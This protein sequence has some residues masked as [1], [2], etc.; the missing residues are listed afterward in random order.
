MSAGVIETK[1]RLRPI[2]PGRGPQAT[3]MHID[4]RRAG[5]EG[6]SAADLGLAH[7]I[8]EAARDCVVPP[9]A[10]TAQTGVEGK[11]REAFQ[12]RF[13]GIEN[14]ASWRVFARTREF[15]NPSADT[16]GHERIIDTGVRHVRA[17]DG[18]KA[19]AGQAVALDP[20]LRQGDARGRTSRLGGDTS[21]ASYEL[22]TRDPANPTHGD[23]AFA[24]FATKFSARPVGIILAAPEDFGVGLSQNTGEDTKASR[25]GVEASIYHR[26][27]HLHRDGITAGT[28]AQY[29]LTNGHL[30]TRRRLSLGLRHGRFRA[31]QWDRG[32]KRRD[33]RVA[34]HQTSSYLRCRQ[35][36]S[37]AGKCH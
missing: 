27:S 16:Q 23:N 20:V 5:I 14:N 2:G 17:E 15:N 1:G 18:F 12:L 11:E 35:H 32:C 9:A 10:Q 4:P 13:F 30:A 26:S 34:A 8:Y 28:I 29:H 25:A 37:V 24:L 7:I 21:D 3:V 31:E 22:D 33:D 36:C 19:L 6:D